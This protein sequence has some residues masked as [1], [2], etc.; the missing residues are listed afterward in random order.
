MRARLPK[1]HNARYP[2]VGKKRPGKRGVTLAVSG[3]RYAYLSILPVLLV[4]AGFSLYPIAYAA[5]LSL[6]R[7]LL[8]EPYDHHF[9]GLFN[10]S[11]VLSNPEVRDSISS[12]GHFVVIVVPTIVI[13]GLFASYIMNQRFVGSKILR[14]AILIPWA[15]PLVV[16]GIIWSWI[17][18][19]DY[20]VLNSILH[21]LH[22]I[23]NYVPWL[24]ESSLARI[25]LVVA[26]TWHEGPFAAVF[27]LA[28]RQAI[29]AEI[30]EAARVDGAGPWTIFRSVTFPMLKP[31]LLIILVY[32]TVLS[33]VTFDLVYVMTG[34]GPG[35]STSLISWFVYNEVFT[36]LNLGDG[37]ALAFMVALA[38]LVV[39]FIYLWALYRGAE[40]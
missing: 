39:I 17:F 19:G 7:E 23:H 36:F 35:D 4:M 13:F 34:G 26:Q 27:L 32:E 16:S 37:A 15:M 10:Y 11:D 1:L 9:T 38:L 40:A 18:N 24:A 20:G 33:V 25:G 31:T 14:V 2:A 5:W 22:V 6:H 29:P 8:I 30:Y 12:T 3:G 28:G 21:S